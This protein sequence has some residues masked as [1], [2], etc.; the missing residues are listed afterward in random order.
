MM[1]DSKRKNY[2]IMTSTMTNTNNPKPLESMKIL[3]HI[4]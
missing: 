3:Y 2:D 4:V 1:I